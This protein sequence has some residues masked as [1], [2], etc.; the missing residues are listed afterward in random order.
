MTLNLIFCF[1]DLYKDL[2]KTLQYSLEMLI[3]F[4]KFSFCYLAPPKDIEL[5][6]RFCYDS[7]GKLFPQLSLPIY[8]SLCSLF[9]IRHYSTGKLFNLLSFISWK[10]I[11]EHIFVFQI[12]HRKWT[13]FTHTLI[14]FFQVGQIDLWVMLSP[15]KRY[16]E[17]I[18]LQIPKKFTL[19]E[20]YHLNHLPLVLSSMFYQWL[21]VYRLAALQRYSIWAT[22]GNLI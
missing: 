7:T 18:T 19:P 3:T 2:Y 17:T 20:N 14:N 15:Y 5:Q 21:T 12:L 10:E 4:L 16:N 8:P 6:W 13:F 11:V 1:I 22:N 9:L